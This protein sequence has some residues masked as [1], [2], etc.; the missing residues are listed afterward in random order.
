MAGAVMYNTGA[1]ML[2]LCQTFTSQTAV[3][4]QMGGCHILL[5]MPVPAFLLCGCHDVLQVSALSRLQSSLVLPSLRSKCIQLT[6]EAI[7]A[8]Q[9]PLQYCLSGAAGPAIP[10][11]MQVA[12]TCQ[13]RD[14]VNASESARRSPWSQINGHC[15]TH[16]K[17]CGQVP[18][19]CM[20]RWH[21][22]CQH[23][24]TQTATMPSALLQHSSSRCLSPFQH[25][26]ACNHHTTCCSPA[27]AVRLGPLDH[28]CA[29]QV[30]QILEDVQDLVSVEHSLD[31]ITWLEQHRVMLL[32]SYKTG[33]Q[34]VPDGCTSLAAGPSITSGFCFVCLRSA[35]VAFV[36]LQH[37]GVDVWHMRR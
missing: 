2:G 18:L 27:A 33:Q 34:Q 31:I 35:A 3:R 28:R 15:V 29:A 9:P 24:S 8:Q 23:H 11:L 37:F 25:L 14:L 4:V 12:I 20:G 16:T 19:R 21:S 7:A 13:E 6:Q 22:T 36:R 1:C 30:L 10:R 17:S 32:S 26:V 5:H